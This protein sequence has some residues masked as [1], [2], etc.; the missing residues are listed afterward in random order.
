MTPDET[1]RKAAR[2][3]CADAVPLVEFEAALDA[4]TA[5]AL[6][7][8]LR[9]RVDGEKPVVHD[10]PQR[11]ACWACGTTADS[12]LPLCRAV[13]AQ[14][15]AA[16][17]AED[18]PNAR[19]TNRQRWGPILQRAIEAGVDLNAIPRDHYALRAATDR[20]RENPEDGPW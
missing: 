4:Y 7:E 1:V 12:H 6:F 16:I 17:D 3:L 15:R 9:R 18:S 5:N 2:Y 13:L 20:D 14:A 19:P 11:P 10:H 8:L